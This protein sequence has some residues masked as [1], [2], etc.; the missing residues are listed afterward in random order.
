MQFCINVRL[1]I[2]KNKINIKINIDKNVLF[3][4]IFCVNR[5]NVLRMI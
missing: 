5:L 3:H 4:I 2:D 1:I